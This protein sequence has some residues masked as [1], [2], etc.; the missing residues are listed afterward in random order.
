MAIYWEIESVAMVMMPFMIMFIRALLSGHGKTGFSGA[1]VGP[2]DKILKF[3]DG[4]TIKTTSGE[5]IKGFTLFLSL[6]ITTHV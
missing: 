5:L 4:W 6:Y 1:G 3:A 2:P